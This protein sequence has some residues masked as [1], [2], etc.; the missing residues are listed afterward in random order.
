[1]YLT[2]RQFTL[3]NATVFILIFATLINFFLQNQIKNS[4]SEFDL[5]QY[6]NNP[7][8]QF[9]NRLMVVNYKDIPKVHVLMI[10]ENNETFN[11]LDKVF[12][13][14]FSGL[15]GSKNMYVQLNKSIDEYQKS[16][17]FFQGTNE[18]FKTFPIAI[19]V[20]LHMNRLI[21]SN[22]FKEKI[23]DVTLFQNLHQPSNTVLNHIQDF[24]TQKEIDKKVDN[25]IT[26]FNKLQGNI[27]IY[28]KG[29][30]AL[31]VT[32]ENLLTDFDT[33]EGTF[34]QQKN[35]TLYN[36][37]RDLFSNLFESFSNFDETKVNLIEYYNVIFEIV[38]DTT[39][40]YTKNSIQEL[41]TVIKIVN[42]ILSSNDQSNSFV[43]LNSEYSMFVFKKIF[44]KI[45]HTDSVLDYN[46][47]DFT[48][49]LQNTGGVFEDSNFFLSNLAYYGT[50]I[51]DP[52]RLTQAVKQMEHDLQIKRNKR[53]RIAFNSKVEGLQYMGLDPFGKKPKHL[54]ISITSKD[55]TSTTYNNFGHVTERR[56]R[57]KNGHEITID[58]ETGNITE[59]KYFDHEWKKDFFN[60]NGELEKQIITYVGKDD[61][62][63]KYEE[64]KYDNRKGIKIIT[65]GRIPKGVMRESFLDGDQKNGIKET[66]MVYS[67]NES[68]GK[69]KFKEL[70]IYGINNRVE[71]IITVNENE[72]KKI[73]INYNN[74][75][76][77]IEESEKI[78]DRNI[79]NNF[80]EKEDIV[81]KLESHFDNHKPDNIYK[82]SK[83]LMD[84]AKEKEELRYSNEGILEDFENL[85]TFLVVYKR[86]KQR[87]EKYKQKIKKMEQ[88]QKT[89]NLHLRGSREVNKVVKSLKKNQ[90]NMKSSIND[91]Y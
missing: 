16:R 31:K 30:Q 22:E 54:D 38:N 91:I 27:K 28:N 61:T 71:S 35:N 76:I 2:R 83:K 51:R 75:E 82:T 47:K 55:G 62:E 81:K 63:M 3:K 59:E 37:Y 70:V 10:P 25:L 1:M 21:Q 79:N 5:Q 86:E 73:K 52:N 17:K 56:K 60:L 84:E 4:Y 58:G 40:L 36:E 19:G 32:V 20:I 80:K 74:E 45:L 42:E 13:L 57:D 89:A 11:R 43:V 78:Y 85:K 34:T 23:A 18:I 9:E 33:Y 68:A 26:Q 49:S 88:Q 24:I 69:N 72:I 44:N 67:T 14:V 64:T 41:I 65:L 29:E 90:K 66:T 39:T 53:D 50:E 46:F 8:S 48:R 7:N 15:L 12:S 87:Q 6:Y 77:T